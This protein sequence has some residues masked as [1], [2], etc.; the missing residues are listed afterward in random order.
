[1][2]KKDIWHKMKIG[3]EGYVAT[4]PSCIQVELF[5]REMYWLVSCS[6]LNNDQKIYVKNVN[7][8]KKVAANLVNEAIKEEM[9]S[10]FKDSEYLT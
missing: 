8:A 4:L 7:E 10:L 2:K 9:K 3:S 5:K 6:R 1:M